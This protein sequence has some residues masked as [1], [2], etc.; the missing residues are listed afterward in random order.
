V[1]RTIIAADKQ[2]QIALDWILQSKS[3]SSTVGSFRRG[4]RAEDGRISEHYHLTEL[5][6]VS[7][8]VRTKRNVR[9]GDGTVVFSL[10][11]IFTGGSALTFEYAG[12][13]PRVCAMEV[14]RCNTHRTRLH[15][16]SWLA[17]A[18]LWQFR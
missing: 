14:S 1:V 7:Y 13:P 10:D 2:A 18:T 8:A 6:S 5:S 12:K 3:V 17:C 11:P 9:E 4:R 15:P 16:L